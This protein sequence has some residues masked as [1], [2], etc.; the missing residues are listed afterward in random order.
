MVSFRRID[1]F[2]HYLVVFEQILEKFLVGFQATS[3]G[4]LAPNGVTN[5][6]QLRLTPFGPF[7]HEDKVRA[8]ARFDGTEPLS[9]RSVGQ[10]RC[11]LVAKLFCYLSGR[12]RFESVLQ[13][14]DIA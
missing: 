12:R 11:E 5:F 6:S 8:V 10:L 9:D 1:F 2:D 14:E 4:P 7:F 3:V 13:K